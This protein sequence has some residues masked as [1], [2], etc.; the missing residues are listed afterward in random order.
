M[1]E[2][3]EKENEDIKAKNIALQDELDSLKVTSALCRKKGKIKLSTCR[4]NSS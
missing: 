4:R 3:I 2:E 1:I